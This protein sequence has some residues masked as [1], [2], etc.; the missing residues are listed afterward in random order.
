MIFG[1][2]MFAFVGIEHPLIDR[3]DDNKLMIV[4]AIFLL[5]SVASSMA[6]TG[7]FEISYHDGGAA[8]DGAAAEAARGTLLFS[9]LATGHL[10]S[11]AELGG[12]EARLKALGLTAVRA[13]TLGAHGGGGS[14]HQH[15]HHH[16]HAHGHAHGHGP[17]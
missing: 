17:M 14:L 6:Q 10:P 11:N 4:G 8:D 16:G 5:N 13:P 3:A 7:A 9:K 2:R 12:I 15:G 1:K